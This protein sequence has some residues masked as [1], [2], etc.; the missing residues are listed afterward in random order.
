M[1]YPAMQDATGSRLRAP[2]KAFEMDNIIGIIED[3]SAVRSQKKFS[4]H[5]NAADSASFLLSTLF[6]LLSVS[7]ARRDR[8]QVTTVSCPQSKPRAYEQQQLHRTNTAKPG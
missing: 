8:W 6:P 5:G 4:N 2:T 3:A 1:A 7:K